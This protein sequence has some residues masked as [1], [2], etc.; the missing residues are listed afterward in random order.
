M[1]TV[2]ISILSSV[3]SAKLNIMSADKTY[4]LPI[5]EK[6]LTNADGSSTFYNADCKSAYDMVRFMSPSV[7]SV[8]GLRVCP[9]T[10]S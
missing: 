2:H 6:F 5:T 3:S 9:G 1:S 4:I 7:F 10:R 8:R